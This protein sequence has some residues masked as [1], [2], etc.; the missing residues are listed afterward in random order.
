M[1][2]GQRVR[3]KSDPGRAGVLTGRFHKLGKTIQFQVMFPEG[4]SYQPEYEI[5]V[6]DDES[7]D[8]FALLKK[9]RFGRI[10]E[11]RRNLSHIQ[12]SGR[13]ANIVYSMDTTNTDFYA[14]QYKPVLSFL[15]SPSNG[16]LIA[17]EVGLGKTIEAGLIWTEL[18]SRYDARRVMVLCL[19]VLREKWQAELRERFG[20]EATILNAEEVLIELRKNK[21]EIPDGKAIICSL[22]GIRPPKNWDDEEEEAVIG[23][24]RR[25]LARFLKSQAES[26]PIIDLLIIDEAHYLRNPETQTAELG[27]LLRA[28][29]EHVVLLSATPLNL[30]EDDLFH[31]LNL[32]DPDTFDAKG[33]FPQVLVGAGVRQL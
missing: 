33:V 27:Q 10:P 9:G 19:A 20:V 15:E 22:Q 23:G 3:L 30:K 24:T 25:E 14:Y 6:I 7:D 32:V 16:L 26:D 29:S 21:S 17:D 31:L 18:R 28:V 11:L 2:A 4:S 1:E 5:E 12:L 8:P 13:L